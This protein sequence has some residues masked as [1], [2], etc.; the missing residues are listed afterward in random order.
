MPR[1]ARVSRASTRALRRT[2][3]LYQ[4]VHS[5]QSAFDLLLFPV[6]PHTLSPLPSIDDSSPP[7]VRVARIQNGHERSPRQRGSTSGICTST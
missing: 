3:S 2:L 7:Y 6:H 5:S 1:D 4:A